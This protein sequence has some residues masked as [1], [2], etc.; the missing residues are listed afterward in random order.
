MTF[1]FAH[2][3]Q[4][5][6]KTWRREIVDDE[7]EGIRGTE[8]AL[9]YFKTV[10]KDPALLDT[11]DLNITDIAKRWGRELLFKI[12][13]YLR[14]GGS[15][16]RGAKRQAKGGLN[17]MPKKKKMCFNRRSSRCEKK[18]EVDEILDC[19]KGMSLAPSVDN[20]IEDISNLFIN[21]QKLRHRGKYRYIPQV[22]NPG[23]TRMK[24]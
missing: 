13:G 16:L 9:R 22:M 20:I 1:F 21:D 10:G 2:P 23:V 4:V 24:P 3:L 12:S 18:E 11:E 17:H 7:V 19:L 14:D 6:F 8:D 5:I 15:V